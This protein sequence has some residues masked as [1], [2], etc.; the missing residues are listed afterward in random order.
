MDLAKVFLAKLRVDRIFKMFEFPALWLHNI[1]KFIHT[2]R[3]YHIIMANC[4]SSVGIALDEPSIHTHDCGFEPHCGILEIIFLIFVE[5]P[6]NS[7]ILNILSTLNFAGKTYS[8]PILAS[9]L[10]VPLYFLGLLRIS[11]GALR[12]SWELL[13]FPTNG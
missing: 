13:E 3:F 1:H 9:L 4:G 8:N 5:K 12:I 10:I 6:R 2:H 11:L 7:N